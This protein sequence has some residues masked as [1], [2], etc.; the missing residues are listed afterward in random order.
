VENCLRTYYLL[1][2]VARQTFVSCR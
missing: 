2:Y 1:R